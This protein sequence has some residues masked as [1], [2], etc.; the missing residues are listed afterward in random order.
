MANVL[1][2]YSLNGHSR[3][4]SA[5]Q[6]LPVALVPSTLRSYIRTE[7]SEQPTAR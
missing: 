3:I 6:R 2:M 4:L 5:A 7:L 1:K